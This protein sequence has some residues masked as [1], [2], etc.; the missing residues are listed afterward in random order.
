MSEILLFSIIGC[1]LLG[2]RPLYLRLL[3]LAP[4][5]SDVKAWHGG[6]S[7]ISR[8][9]PAQRKVPCGKPVPARPPRRGLCPSRSR[10]P[11]VRRALGRNPAAT[12]PLSGA[13]RC[14]PI[15]GEA[16]IASG[17][18][19]QPD[20]RGCVCV[21]SLGCK[22]YSLHVCQPV[23]VLAGRRVEVPV[24]FVELVVDLAVLS[25]GLAEPDTDWSTISATVE[26][27]GPGGQKRVP[28][29]RPYGLLREVL[30]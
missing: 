10:R 7:G 5:I 18:H 1:P 12:P 15:N 11:K 9:L 17:R 22:P 26:P 3:R 4:W 20:D 28:V 6:G 19:P 16:L 13:Q 30:L 24:D 29:A 21:S 23:H 27:N 8:S 14:R 2:W 25:V